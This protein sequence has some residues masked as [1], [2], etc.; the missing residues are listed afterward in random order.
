MKNISHKNQFTQ[1]GVE[2]QTSHLPDERATNEKLKLIYTKGYDKNN[3][4]R[5]V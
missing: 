4:S 3:T 5:S 1:P 2:P